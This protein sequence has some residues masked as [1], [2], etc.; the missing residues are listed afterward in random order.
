MGHFDSPR[1]PPVSLG[2][3]TPAERPT[4]TYAELAGIFRTHAPPRLP[5]LNVCAPACVVFGK[6]RACL[7]PLAHFLLTSRHPPKRTFRTSILLAPVRIS[8]PVRPATN[9]C[10]ACA[11]SL[12]V[13]FLCF[14]CPGL[15]RAISVRLTRYCPEASYACFTR[16]QETRA[17]KI[18][19][20]P[21]DN[22]KNAFDGRRK[23]N[24]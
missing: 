5:A 22:P 14:A 2:H 15:L 23:T 1:R 10:C 21:Q 11:P 7:C 20:S 24:L 6:R 8:A 9:I 3:A 19:T 12:Q 17:G 18:P 13:P 4:L 16:T